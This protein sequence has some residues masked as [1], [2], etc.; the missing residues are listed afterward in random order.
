M[1]FK[2]RAILAALVLALA[3]PSQAQEVRDPNQEPKK[4]EAALG[5]RNT[6]GYSGRVWVPDPYAVGALS[7]STKISSVGD[8]V[9]QGFSW[10]GLNP[11]NGDAEMDLGGSVIKDF[12]FYKDKIKFSLGFQG[13]VYSIPLHGK[14][15]TNSNFEIVA[16]VPVSEKFGVS[17]TKDIRNLSSYSIGTGYNIPIDNLP[18][19]HKG[20]VTF[21]GEFSNSYTFGPTAYASATLGWGPVY[22]MGKLSKGFHER[23]GESLDK[24]VPMAEAGLRWQF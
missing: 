12:S 9:V 24:A 17:F 4:F 3:S 21:R 22:V 6:H 16:R 8:L 1:M 18:L 5:V 10:F 7:A 15:E 20:S 14:S 11:Q 23:P 2:D 13:A 19:F